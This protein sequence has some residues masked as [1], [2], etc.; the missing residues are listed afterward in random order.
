MART[1]P[2]YLEHSLFTRKL[3]TQNA[4]LS[5]VRV[6]VSVFFGGETHGWIETPDHSHPSLFFLAIATRPR[7]KGVSVGVI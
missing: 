2:L 6:F 1:F 7:C 5:S 4:T 3:I